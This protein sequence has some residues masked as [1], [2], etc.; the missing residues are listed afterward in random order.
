[1]TG[2]EVVWDLES[3]PISVEE[4]ES[5][6]RIFSHCEPQGNRKCSTE[7]LIMCSL[8]AWN[9]IDGN[10]IVNYPGV[11]FFLNSIYESLKFSLPDSRPW[12]TL[13]YELKVV[14]TSICQ[15]ILP[16][17]LCVDV[18]NSRRGLAAP[19]WITQPHLQ[20]GPT[21]ATI[22]GLFAGSSAPLFPASRK[23]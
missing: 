19:K 15:N 8:S 12:Q 20:P 10:E 5:P 16:G 11:L 4:R 14:H 2:T 17:Q 21:S 1:M 13:P 3:S 18:A 22:S 7:N 9:E 23:R 6:S